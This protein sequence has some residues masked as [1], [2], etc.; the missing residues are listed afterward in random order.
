MGWLKEK[1]LDWL[2]SL[3]FWA[4]ARKSRG[5]KQQVEIEQ[6]L[7]VVLITNL[8]TRFLAGRHTVTVICDQCPSS[9]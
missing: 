1:S 5:E 4:I 8:R 2:A 9:L 7:V 6:P 3:L